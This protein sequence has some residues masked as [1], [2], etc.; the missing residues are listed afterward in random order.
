M[1]E[2]SYKTKQREIILNYFSNNHEKAYTIDEIVEILKESGTVVG[3]T[4]VYRY[5]DYLVKSGNLR[6]FP[7]SRG[8]SG[9]YQYVEHADECSEHIHLKCVS[10]GKFIHLGCDF[11]SNICE[12]ISEHHNFKVDNSKSTFFGLCS[13][14]AEK[15]DN[16]GID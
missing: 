10:C 3:R 4:T 7:Q 11:V 8:K 1:T 5:C 12:H 2:P 14:C 13:D 15:G 9:T 6:F 16:N